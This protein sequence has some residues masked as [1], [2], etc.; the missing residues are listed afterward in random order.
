[1]SH[2]TVLVI[3]DDVDGQL[4][5]F[6]ENNMGDC[7]AGYMEFNDLTEDLTRDYETDTTTRVVMPDGRLLTTH[8]DAFR[9]KAEPFGN[10]YKVPEDLEQRQVPL[11]ELY[12]FKE[13]AEDYCGYRFDEEKNAYGYWENPNAKWDWYQVGGRWSGY[14][15]L[16]QGTTG[17]LGK[18]SLLAVMDKNYEPPTS[19]YADQCRKRDIDFEG[20][21][22]VAGDAAAATY[23]KAIA[24]MGDTLVSYVP[25][26]K[27]REEMFPGN[28]D[29]A[30]EFYNTQD[31]V[32]A[33]KADND[34]SWHASPGD[35]L[36]TREEAI[37][38]AQDHAIASFAVLKDGTWYEKGSMGWGCVTGEKDDWAEEFG[39]LLDSLSDDTLL[40]IVDC[41]I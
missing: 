40:T 36:C 39:K 23:D 2:F 27:V 33:L 34:F 16:K 11:K 37:Q 28:I 22:Q 12:T 6:Q 31:A 8:D 38:E 14:F 20:M 9:I 10:S 25:W 19:D 32:R 3:G 29:A 4:A 41:H 30:R 21:R 17:E 18:A 24:L 26:D 1:M 15:K 13:Y 35:F 5:P 7:P